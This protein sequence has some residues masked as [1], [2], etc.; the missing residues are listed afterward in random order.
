MENGRGRDGG[1]SRS[2]RGS[3]G[4]A[5]M[6]VDGLGRSAG[7]RITDRSQNMP[8]RIY[9]QAGGLGLS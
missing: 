5:G 3:G 4:G 6:L 2:E 1:K 9:G 8:G 7:N